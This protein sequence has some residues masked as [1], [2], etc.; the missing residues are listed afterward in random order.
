[1]RDLKS[2]GVMLGGIGAVTGLSIL[3]QYAKS[4]SLAES[5]VKRLMPYNGFL[6]NEPYSDRNFATAIYDLSSGIETS[7]TVAKDRRLQQ[8]AG[9]IRN[10]A[11]QLQNDKG[12]D[13]LTE[14]LVFLGW[15]R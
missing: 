2:I 5:D 7:A 14:Q 3:S 13:A 11:W 12:R 15:I 8:M 1:M 9:L 4:R 6:P 10:A